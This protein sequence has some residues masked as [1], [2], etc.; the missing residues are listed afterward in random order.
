MTSGRRFYITFLTCLFEFIVHAIPKA[1]F[2]AAIETTQR[3]AATCF[4]LKIKEAI[5]FDA[6]T[7]EQ[8]GLAGVGVH[9]LLE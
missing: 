9:G 8:T 1:V 2:E 5:S 6:M 7:T 3:A 4:E